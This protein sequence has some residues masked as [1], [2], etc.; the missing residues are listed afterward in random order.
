LRIE[1]ARLEA[2]WFYQTGPLLAT[3]LL[4]RQDSMTNCLMA[5]RNR[6]LIKSWRSADTTL[7]PLGSHT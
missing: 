5:S 6:S 1:Q 3:G 7:P 4:N 2:D